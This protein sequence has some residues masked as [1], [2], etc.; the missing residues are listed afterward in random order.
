MLSSALIPVH[1][2]GLITIAGK[3]AFTFLQGQLTCDMREINETR[4]LFGAC[5]NHKGRMMAN[6]FVFQQSENYYFLLPKSMVE[7]TITHLKKYAVFSKVELTAADNIKAVEY[8]GSEIVLKEMDENTWRLTNIKAGWVWI[9]PKTSDILVPQMINLQKWGGVNF[10]KGCYIGQ[11][12]IARSEYL[13]KLKRHLYRANII[14]DKKPIPGE[15][16]KN[17]NGQPV[18]V[19]VEAAQKEHAEYELLAVLQSHALEM[20][21]ILNQFNLKNLE[22][23]PY[24]TA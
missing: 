17:Q 4:C 22:K 11:E 9:Y 5:C 1:Y 13:G 24:P 19:V 12:I 21:I 23:A 15:E 8:W 10:N 18:G 14:C 20:K 7:P 2:F 16:L 6:F 3:N